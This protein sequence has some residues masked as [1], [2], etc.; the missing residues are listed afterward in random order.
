MNVDEILTETFVS[1]E[2]LSPDPEV[3]LAALLAKTNRR[4]YA[5][6]R[7]FAVLGAAVMVGLIATAV[8]L[9]PV[10]S[11]KTAGPARPGQSS[12]R[13]TPSPTLTSAT[14]PP[15]GP[16]ALYTTI[17]AGWLPKQS[18][19]VF[20]QVY[21]ET[22]T[23]RY[24]STASDPTLVVNMGLR[25]AAKFPT[26]STKGTNVTVD[27]LPARGFPLTVEKYGYLIAIKVDATH[28]LT[29]S[30]ISQTP[31][32]RAIALHIARSLQRGRHDPI[33][34]AFS[35]SDLPAGLR[36]RGITYRTGAPSA[37]T[38]Y[39]LARPGAPNAVTTISS[40]NA[41]HGKASV[42]PPGAPGSPTRTH[43]R[44]FHGHSTVVQHK[45]GDGYD[46]E[47]S[48]AQPGTAL[49]ISGDSSTT[50]ATLYRIANSV[51]WER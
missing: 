28:L 25:S 31:G 11:D 3:E 51:T 50:L 8:A 17:A 26:S 12:H 37:G 30:V 41:A 40:T 36:V 32:T 27:G 15:T 13:S 47:I 48:E 45:S 43:G 1:H 21:D 6:S 23:L 42:N 18:T 33:H 7:P 29:V 19:L 38:S 16:A 10:L 9:L 14:K 24:A 35:F 2:A 22:E 49:L 5:I 39:Y 46:L 4:R 20:Q 44:P 34:T